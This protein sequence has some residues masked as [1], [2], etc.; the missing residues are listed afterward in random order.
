MTP[1]NPHPFIPTAQTGSNS[2]QVFAQDNKCYLIIFICFLI[3]LAV[4]IKIYFDLYEYNPI[5]VKIK[6]NDNVETGMEELSAPINNLKS[7]VEQLINYHQQLK[8]DK[9]SLLADIAKLQAALDEQK[10]TIEQLEKANAALIENNNNEQKTVITETRTKINELVQ[11][12]DNCIALL[13]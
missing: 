9:E 11:E 12:I 2:Y 4:I 6:K 8:Q 7:K 5:F 3:Y 10:A 1:L 13:K